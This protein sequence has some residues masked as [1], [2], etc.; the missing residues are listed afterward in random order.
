MKYTTLFPLAA[1]LTGCLKKPVGYVLLESSSREESFLIIEK[2]ILEDELDKEVENGLPWFIAKDA[3]TLGIRTKDLG[4]RE[5]MEANYL[6]ELSDYVLSL[7]QGIHEL[8]KAS[9]VFDFDC[10]SCKEY[11][12]IISD[13]NDVSESIRIQGQ[14][15]NSYS[16]LRD[17]VEA[18]LHLEKLVDYYQS[19]FDLSVAKI[20]ESDPFYMKWFCGE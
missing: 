14:R 4:E 5:S 18:E 19:E 12:Q 7:N 20:R 10:P 3:K 8:N 16:T 13:L 1:V 2:M 15:V 11:L 17:T 9:G 6:S